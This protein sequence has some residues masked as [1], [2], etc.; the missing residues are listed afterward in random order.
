MIIN[1]QKGVVLLYGGKLD[2]AIAQLKKTV[3][4]FPDAQRPRSNL[5]LTYFIKGM[6]SEGVEQRLIVEKLAGDSPELIKTRQLAFE[7]DGYQGFVQRQLEIQLNRQRLSL[8]KD[9]NAFFPANGIAGIYSRLQDK[10]KTLE[11]LNKAYEQ[12]EPGITEI[13]VRPS[14]NF[15]RDDPRFKELVK[16]VGFPE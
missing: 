14:H 13:K 2:E 1:S 8:E 11:Y 10:D 7:K 15:L 6:Y 3:D 5:T 4:L 9:K 12:R 16:K